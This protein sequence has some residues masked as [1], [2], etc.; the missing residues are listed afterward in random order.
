MNI[1]S[2]TYI[3]ITPQQKEQARAT[4]IA[5]FLRRK[6]ES[7]KQEGQGY[8]WISGGEKVSIK[9]NFWYDQYTQEGGDAID[10]AR[11]F[12]DCNSF[13]EA[14]ELLVGENAATIAKGQQKNEKSNKQFALPCSHK[15]MYRVYAYLIHQRG[16][17][18][19]VIN[20][21]IRE[22]LLYEEADYHNC[23]FIGYDE[24]G[25]PRHAHKRGTLSGSSFKCNESGSDPKYSFHRNGISDRLYVFEAP[26]DM[27]S[28]IS[29]HKEG[30]Q[31]HS[32][33]ALCS[34]APHAALNMIKLYPNLKKVILGLDNDSAGNA[35]CE[36]IF[37][38]I[39]RDHP[40]VEVYRHSPINKD[41]NEDLTAQREIKESEVNECQ[42]LEY[43]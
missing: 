17:D 39:K 43:L 8:A 2:K 21:F 14:I 5:D 23:V 36:R 41:F 31:D 33:V 24:N 35:A 26:I 32:Y 30:W 15:N 4:D 38:L 10:F 1:I 9:G 42:T 16:I 7:V 27:M 22:H 6:G 12:F 25:I 19:D 3:N 40:E 13:F 11:R 29:M 37:G 28:Y 20:A 18:R 34:V